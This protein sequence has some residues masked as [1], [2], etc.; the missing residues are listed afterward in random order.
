MRRNDLRVGIFGEVTRTIETWHEID[1]PSA[2]QRQTRPTHA[3]GVSSA[4]SAARARTRAR[5]C[6]N[7]RPPCHR[8]TRGQPSPVA[9]SE[10]ARQACSSSREARASP[11]RRRARCGPR[12]R[13]C[14]TMRPL[15][16]GWR[17]AEAKVHSAM[18]VRAGW[19]SPKAGCTDYID[20]AGRSS[21][22]SKWAERHAVRTAPADHW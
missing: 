1:A 3:E 10:M 7:S 5:G 18:G 6:L 19:P 16:A 17:F 14:C 11:L 21:P 22:R 8:L 15:A 4:C 2:S 13:G 20:Q 9:H 12:V